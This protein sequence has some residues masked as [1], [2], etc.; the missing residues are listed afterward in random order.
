MNFETLKFRKFLNLIQA[1]DEEG[2]QTERR[3]FQVSTA[4]LFY[5]NIHEMAQAYLIGASGNVLKII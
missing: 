3:C 1:V 5:T 2:L 4:E